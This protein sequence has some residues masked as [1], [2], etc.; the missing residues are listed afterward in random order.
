M[1]IKIWYTHI[2]SLLKVTLICNNYNTL[3]LRNMKWKRETWSG[4]Q[5]TRKIL[6]LGFGIWESELVWSLNVQWL[7]LIIDY[8]HRQVCFKCKLISDQGWIDIDIMSDSPAMIIV[9]HKHIS[10]Q[11]EWSIS[12]EFKLKIWVKLV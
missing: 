7:W 5:V 10:Y 11:F 4:K 6:L 8:R 12:P 1:H 3:L 9:F 2:F